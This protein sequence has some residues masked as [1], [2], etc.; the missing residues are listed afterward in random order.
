ML[1]QL[2]SARAVLLKLVARMGFADSMLALSGVLVPPASL[3]GGA[4]GADQSGAD[5]QWRRAV[6]SMR[7][8][9]QQVRRRR[10]WEPRHADTR[11]GRA[12]HSSLR[13]M[14]RPRQRGQR[15]RRLVIR[16]TPAAA[17]WAPAQPCARQPLR[18]PLAL[19]PRRPP[20]GH[21]V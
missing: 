2:E 9:A 17:D 8:D 7:L 13:R 14:R 5:M 15:P 16:P 11:A 18:R 6:Q 4:A 20:G 3:G 1:A 10:Q 12:A 21:P 19:R